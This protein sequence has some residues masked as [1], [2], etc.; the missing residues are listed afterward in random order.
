[1]SVT[2]RSVLRWGGAAVA[3][4]LVAPQI[5]AGP[6]LAVPL[7][8]DP[9]T[10]GVASGDPSPDGVVLWTRLAPSPLDPDGGMPGVPVQ[11]NWQ[12]A[13]DERFSD[14]V[15]A[16]SVRAEPG[17]AHS[18][19]VEVSGLLPDRVYFYRFRAGRHLSPV[20]RT[21]TFPAA[22]AAVTSMTLAAVSCQSL[23]AGRYAAY[24]HLAA[25][26]HDLVL[27]LGD[28][29]YEA[30]GAANPKAGPDRRH[31]PFKVIRTLEEYRIRHAQYRL[32]PDLQAAHAAAPFLCVPDDHEVVNNAAGDLGADGNSTPEVYLP[33][34]AAAF[35]AYYEHLP[36][37]RSSMPQG[38]AMQLYRRLDY[39]NLA[40]L[41]LLDTRQYRS[42]QE[43]GPTFQRL[44][45]S[46]Y[47]VARTMTGPDQERWL[48]AGLA[49]SSA[50]WN[51]IGQQVYFAAIDMEPGDAEFY[52]TD[53][54]DGYPAARS[55]ITGFL[56]QR[57]PRNPVVLSGD[58]HA[59]MVND[60]TLDADP[61]SPVVA[62][63]FLGSSITSEKGN[64]DLFEAALP[65]NPQVR[66][67]NGRQRGY[68]SCTV[69][70]EQWTADL[71]FVDDVLDAG[72]PVRKGASYV[73]EDGRP[74]AQPA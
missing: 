65:E 64:N 54:W 71:W 59:A 58:V 33:R 72:S 31:A 1:M 55:R 73:L 4:A 69:T 35:Q 28:Y 16:G 57:R 66:Y 8:A 40:Q 49:A 60:I 18:V 37:R 44:K 42:P 47:D 38:P 14:V 63:E 32:D 56:H 46:A 10:L 45:P 61:T 36:L 67:Y 5:T 2:R 68:L 19:H 62:T 23:P 22:G 3:T 29:I 24:R 39:G 53:K 43:D 34:R 21:R 27:H 9:F 15:R 26:D 7:P 52:N 25:G 20:G 41:T 12:V 17:W 11:V 51:V 6:A 70:P 74:G 48:L 30:A 50:R 13:T